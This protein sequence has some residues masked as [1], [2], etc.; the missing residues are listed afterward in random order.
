[1]LRWVKVF[2]MEKKK[3]KGK[4]GRGFQGQRQTSI[5]ISF[6]LTP[7]GLAPIFH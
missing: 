7:K 5:L 3:K 2:L 1:M 6:F 4:K